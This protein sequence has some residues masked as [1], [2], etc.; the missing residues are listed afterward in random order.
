M[1]AIPYGFRHFWQHLSCNFEKN[2]FLP[3]VIVSVNR[4][5]KDINPLMPGGN[6]KVT[7]LFKYV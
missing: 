7:G 5:R 1:L 2:L 3:G 4:Q 6:K